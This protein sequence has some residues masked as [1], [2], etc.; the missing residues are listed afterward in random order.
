MCWGLSGFSTCSYDF[1]IGLSFSSNGVVLDSLRLD[2]CRIVQVAAIEDRRGPESAADRLE[3]GAAE[4]LPLRDDGERVRAVQ[5][6]E[7]GIDHLEAHLVQVD[8]ARLVAGRRI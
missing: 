2:H 7:R 8:L 6:G 4:L 1:S 3:V 5:R